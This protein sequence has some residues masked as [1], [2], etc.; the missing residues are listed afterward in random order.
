MS[1]ELTPEQQA[2]IEHRVSAGLYE[3]PVAMIDKALDVLEEKEHIRAKQQAFIQ[4][5]IKPAWDAAKRGETTPLNMGKLR[6]KLR[7]KWDAEGIPR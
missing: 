3:S 2:I 6:S 4:Q 5:E 1:I 7:A